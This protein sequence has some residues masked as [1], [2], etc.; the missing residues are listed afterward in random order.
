MAGDWT[1]ILVRKETAQRIR[2][3]A[4]FLLDLHCRGLVEVE[5][6]ER[7]GGQKGNGISSD[8]VIRILLDFKEKH[9]ARAR[10]QRKGK[11]VVAQGNDAGESVPPASLALTQS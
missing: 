6:T 4:E 11:P 8:Q 7:S 1:T 5:V 3:E 2:A 9:R 10:R